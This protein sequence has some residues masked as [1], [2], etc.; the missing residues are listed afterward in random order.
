MTISGPLWC[1]RKTQAEATRVMR[2]VH[3]HA[4]SQQAVMEQQ[5]RQ[6]RV[7]AAHQQQEEASCR[8][9]AHLAPKAAA[10]MAGPDS[11]A[12]YWPPSSSLAAQ[13]R[14]MLL[15]GMQQCCICW[16]LARYNRLLFDALQALGHPLPPDLKRC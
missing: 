10:D 9:A 1:V 15:H 2:A 8:A 3:E 12:G 14:W 6:Q 5:E 16:P 4:I 7:A 13:V 11:P